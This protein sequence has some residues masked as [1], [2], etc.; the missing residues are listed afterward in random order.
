MSRQRNE[1]LPQSKNVIVLVN[2]GIK[3]WKCLF[4][5]FSA[6][7]INHILSPGPGCL[8]LMLDRERYKLYVT[9]NCEVLPILNDQSVF[10]ITV[11]NCKVWRI[12]SIFCFNTDQLLQ[13]NFS[14]VRVYFQTTSSPKWFRQKYTTNHITTRVKK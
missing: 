7:I 6:Q 13:V 10:L 1:I 4:L 3:L 12:P 9:M 8:V 11:P 5:N 14:F 2:P